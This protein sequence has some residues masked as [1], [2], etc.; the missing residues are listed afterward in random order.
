MM[1]Y[2]KRPNNYASLVKTG[3]SFSN[4]YWLIAKCLQCN[5]MPLISLKMSIAVVTFENLVKVKL[6]IYNK[7]SCNYASWIDG[8]RMLGPAKQIA[9]FW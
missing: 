5:C 3:S 6:L 7:R 8:C 4:G 2:H 1:A 9:W